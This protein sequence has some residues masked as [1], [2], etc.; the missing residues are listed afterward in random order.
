M[1]RTIEIC[2]YIMGVVALIA[3][4]CGHWQHLGTAALI[5]PASYWEDEEDME[6]AEDSYWADWDMREQEAVDRYFGK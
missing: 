6:R 3:A 2:C 1:N 5:P 4:L